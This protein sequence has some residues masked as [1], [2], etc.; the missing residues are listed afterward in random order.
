MHLMWISYLRSKLIDQAAYLI[1]QHG[2]LIFSVSITKLF[3]HHLFGQ[4]TPFS[5][6]L[7]NVA[8]LICKCPCQ[9]MSF[10]FPFFPGIHLS[11]FTPLAHDS[12]QFSF[13]V[14]RYLM[15]SFPHL[16]LFQNYFG[17]FCP[18]HIPYEFHDWFVKF[19]GRLV[20]IKLFPTLLRHKFTYHKHIHFKLTV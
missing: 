20:E 9:W 7:F 1:S 2:C 15:G 14:T 13:I 8:L 3:W 19:Q 11:I 6:L 18:L 10:Q 17:Y 16:V 5:F 4:S 12:N